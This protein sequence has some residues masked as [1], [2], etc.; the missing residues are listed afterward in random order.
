MLSV[1]TGI[2]RHSQLPQ[3]QGAIPGQVVEA[4]QV[5]AEVLPP[6]QKDIEHEE[7][8]A[9]LWQVLGGRVVGVCDQPDGILLA[10][11]LDELAEGVGD[12]VDP[13]PAQDVGGHFITK[14]ESEDLLV[15]GQAPRGLADLFT[16]L[17]D[18]PP[19]LAPRAPEHVAP[20]R[21]EDAGQEPKVVVRC[22]LQDVLCGHGVRP[23]DGEPV[24]MD[25]RHVA[26]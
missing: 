19:L 5:A 2:R 6:F 3:N 11:D 22:G 15:S 18:D 13:V 4:R 12:Q 16:R 26:L 14:R 20:V 21:V 7:V 1:R 25:R 23:N 9:L 17:A 8:E 10:N 24:L